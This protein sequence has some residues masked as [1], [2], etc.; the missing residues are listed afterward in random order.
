MNDIFHPGDAL[1]AMAASTDSNPQDE[2]PLWQFDLLENYQRPTLPASGAM[3]NAWHSVRQL[4]RVPE[5]QT[6]VS[7]TEAP[8]LHALTARQADQ[9]MP[10]P[11]SAPQVKALHTAL[12]DW[13]GEQS[14]G[15]SAQ[16]I[17]GQPGNGTDQALEILAGHLGGT[18]VSPPPVREILAGDGRWLDDWPTDSLWI[19]PNLEACFLRTVQG[20]APIRHFFDHLSSGRL[21]KGII[22]CDSW[23]WAY[24]QK[25]WPVPVPALALQAFDAHRLYRLLDSLAPAAARP[26][27]IHHAI[28]GKPVMV[29]PGA[30][31]QSP[32]DYPELT[33]MAAQSR[34][35]PAQALYHWRSRL[36][37]APESSA[38]KATTEDECSSP[39][40]NTLWLAATP[41]EPVVPLSSREELLLVLHTLLLH[42]GVDAALVPEL[43]P[44]ADTHCQWLLA[45]LHQ[46]GLAGPDKNGK[47]RVSQAG[48]QS[49]CQI[50]RGHQYLLDYFQRAG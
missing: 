32:H 27:N 3:A 38:D 17:I 40:S 37:T 48:Y 2:R 18:L 26:L 13:L 44:F 28:S 15:L 34:G 11:E 35:N 8:D 19:L 20:I 25:V 49:V 22:G 5:K 33:S 1:Q 10:L 16:F 41:D 43:L 50:L 23:A 47:W 45:C 7:T 21:G 39:D 36:R 46:A 12:A 31:G 42:G 30:A 6:I 9:V 24:L 14:P 4:F 29:V